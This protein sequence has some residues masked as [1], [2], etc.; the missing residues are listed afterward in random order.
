M[1]RL[2]S[3][4]RKIFR[5][6]ATKNIVVSGD[7][8]NV[9]LKNG[10]IFINGKKKIINEPKVNL[11]VEG[12]VSGNINGAFSSIIIKKGVLGSVR[13]TSGDIIIEGDACYNVEATNGD[14]A[15]SGSCLTATSK[16]GNVSVQGKVKNIK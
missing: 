9:E 10:S 12:N 1:L 6:K 4:L 3:R 7:C 8:T 14:I 16:N 15:I 2:L 5:L 13:A 11:I